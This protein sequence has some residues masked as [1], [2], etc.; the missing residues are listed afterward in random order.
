MRHNKFVVPALLTV[1]VIVGGVVG[2]VSASPDTFNSKGRIEL[3]SV[4]FDSADF[5]TIQVA[6][7][8]G[9]QESYNDGKLA[10]QNEVIENPADYGI[11]MGDSYKQLTKWTSTSFAGGSSAVTVTEDYPVVFVSFG[12]GYKPHGGNGYSLSPW[13]SCSNGSGVCILNDGFSYTFSDERAGGSGA[14]WIFTD[15]KAGDTISFGFSVNKGHVARGSFS[16]YGV[17]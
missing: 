17:K 2:R 13:A 6:Y 9:K 7:E 3:E 14:G 12:G 4:I 16:V 11:S 1:S 10:G 15:V 5:D 8:A